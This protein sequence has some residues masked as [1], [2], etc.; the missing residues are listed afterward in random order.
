MLGANLLRALKSHAHEPVVVNG[1][2]GRAMQEAGFTSLFDPAELAILGIFEVLPKAAVVL[3]RVRQV[4]EDID[5]VKPDLLVTIDSWGFTGRVHKA[6]ARQGSPIKRVRYVAPQVWAWRP[7]RAKQL[8]GWIDHLLTLFP[9]EPPLFEYYGLSVTWV[10]HPVMESPFRGDGDRFRTIHT[11]LPD[12][13]VISVLPGSRTSEVNALM[14]V[15]E[16]T[17][18]RLQGQ[19]SDMHVVVPTVP[20]VEQRVREWADSLL[21]PVTVVTND[22]QREDA[23]AASVVALA[24][25][26]TI[27]LELAKARVPHAVAYKVN[28]LSALAFR[29]LSRT[30]YVNLNN[31]IQNHS[32][33]PEFLQERCKADVLSEAILD[34][35]ADEAARK[36]Q[37]DSFAQVLHALAPEGVS[38]S[39]RAAQVIMTLIGTDG[40]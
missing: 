24:A 3:R 18:S 22:Q 23:F 38:P 28:P 21:M 19:L 26:G 25:S 6:L 4:L 37:Q 30:P 9:F 14:P 7:G 35:V 17:L 2:G 10:G 15:F 13:H 39:Q 36:K 20:N 27:T 33:V 31:I 29:H 12:T 1:V 11:L 34:L 40:R 16:K 5:R 32:V 8:A